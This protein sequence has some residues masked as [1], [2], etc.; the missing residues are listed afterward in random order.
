MDYPAVVTYRDLQYYIWVAIYNTVKTFPSVATIMA[1]L[2]HRNAS[3][4][5]SAQGL[6][7]APKATCD[8]S[9]PTWSSDQARSVISCNDADG[10][11]PLD[12]EADWEAHVAYLVNQ[13]SYIGATWAAFGAA[14]RSYDVRAPRG[15]VFAGF[16][17]A[18]TSTATPVL[19]VRNTLDPVAPAAEKMSGFFDG[20]AV[21]TLDGV[22]HSALVI[23][24]QCI[25]DRVQ[26][27]L[28]DG[29]LPEEGLVCE[30]DVVPFLNE[31]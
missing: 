21:L 17:P 23:T 25:N 11:Y 4:L 20:S 9:G 28:E 24:S 18:G 13:S 3:A 29:V 31:W 2:E 8:Y 12:T 14:C 26:A 22:G 6:G 30:A 10:R 7:L 19:F 5:A 15:Q 27:Y 16:D 1:Q